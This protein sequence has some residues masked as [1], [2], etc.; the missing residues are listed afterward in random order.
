MRRTLPLLLALSACSF[1]GQNVY[2]NALCRLDEDGDGD[3]RCGISNT[4]SDGDCDDT[5]PLMFNGNT[6]IPYD[7]LD[8][9][10]R[11]GDLLDVDGDTFPGISR[12]EYEQLPVHE[13]WPRGL[14]ER[15]D[16]QD[17]PIEGFPA[18]YEA[19]IYPDAPEIWYD[20]LDGN[21]NGGDDFDQDGDGFAAAAYAEFYTQVYQGSLPAT[22]CLDTDRFVYPGSTV[23]DQPYDGIDQACSG[24]NNFDP[25][26]DGRLT[27]GYNAD[28]ASFALRYGYDLTWIPD[29]DCLDIGDTFPEGPADPTLA[30]RTFRRMPGDGTCPPTAR[31]CED[32]WYD[33]YDD[34]CDDVVAGRAVRNDFDQDG[35][36]FVRSTGN[37]SADR[38]AFIA[39][40]RRY[41]EFTNSRGARPFAAAYRATY[42][43]TDETIGAWFDAHSNDCDDLDPEINPSA[44]ER[45][46]DGV[47]RDCDGDPDTTGF[48][49]GTITWFDPGPPRAIETPGHVSVLLAAQGGIDLGDGFDVR[50]TRSVALSWSASATRY[51]VDAAPFTLPGGA[52]D[53][54]SSIAVYGESDGYY[55]A[56]S[57]TLDGAN[58]LLV[59]RSSRDL[60]SSANFFVVNDRDSGNRPAAGRAYVG[61]D[62]RCD[63]A[64]DRCWTV[65]CDATSLHFMEVDRGS[66]LTRRTVGFDPVSVPGG[67]QDC[68]VLSG[69]QSGD[70]ILFGAL[71]GDGTLHTFERLGLGLI[72]A[73]INPMPAGT[74]DFVRSHQDWLIL[75]RTGGGVTLYRSPT[76]QQQIL[77][78]TRW[79]DVDATAL[80]SGSSRTWTVAAID[81]SGRVVLGY[82][83]AT[84][85]TLVDLSI[86]GDAGPLV[87]DS[88][89]VAANESRVVVAV[90]G[91]DGSTPRLAWTVLDAPR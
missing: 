60:A 91:L 86:E 31:T 34:A 10:C 45:L 4:T 57:W 26:G 68:F 65:A 18:G 61:N 85:L 62:I 36:G 53:L 90:R 59:S 82:G 15:V 84:T 63:D 74:Y 42:G 67:V 48:E 8:N 80:G 27:P 30:A 12:E 77:T 28:A 46:G 9:D 47:D 54:D 66:S 40:V 76:E 25:D 32:T 70:G 51:A 3:P 22:D 2:Q 83:P 44:R 49:F 79:L 41:L 72:P 78:G 1:V 21:C 24:L 16:C 7:G 75:G 13:P 11:D 39:Y 64:T 29:A 5:N 58:R 69:S 55:T 14:S 73:G 88:I 50:S 38:A 33:G 37:P 56:H 35:D 43:D 52:A 20:G 19:L 81:L 23:P 6:E 17:L 89:A 71:A 87:A